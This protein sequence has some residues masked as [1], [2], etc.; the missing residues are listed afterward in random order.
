MCITPIDCS[1]EKKIGFDA[2]TNMA[3]CEFIT[4]QLLIVPEVC[5]DGQSFNHD[6][7]CVEEVRFGGGGLRRP[8]RRIATRNVSLKRFLRLRFGARGRR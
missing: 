7:E 2:K 1:S 8:P 4:R 6:G 3:N 5:P